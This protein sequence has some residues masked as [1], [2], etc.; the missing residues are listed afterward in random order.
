[1]TK[2][3]RVSKPK[4][5]TTA[6][7]AAVLNKPTVTPDELHR[8]KIYPLGRNGIFAAC[9]TGEIECFRVGK[10]LIIPTAPLRRKLVLGFPRACKSD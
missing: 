5:A 1:M 6:P 4:P 10:R 3:K 9:R 8:A 7:V 2:R